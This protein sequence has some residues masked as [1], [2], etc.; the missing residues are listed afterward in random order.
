[1]TEET[2]GEAPELQQSEVAT[3]EPSNT[4][5]APK[6]KS[7]I[8]DRP[9]WITIT[10][11]AL[12]P[13][14]AIIALVMSIKSLNTSRDSLRIGQR[15]YVQ[16]SLTYTQR[17]DE[18][19]QWDFGVT[20]K[21]T[22]NTPG[23]LVSYTVSARDEYGCIGAPNA[24]YENHDDRLIMELEASKLKPQRRFSQEEIDRVKKCYVDP[25]VHI[26]DN[27]A[28]GG[29]ESIYK[30]IM[31]FAAI[32]KLDPGN[33]GV[34]EPTIV[35]EFSYRDVFQSV[36]HGKMSCDL[37]FIHNNLFVSCTADGD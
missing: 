29:K 22:G 10:L 36:H 24:V 25:P 27:A 28:I 14:L 5:M 1:M 15:A 33:M 18:T 30:R 17:P 32:P 26:T 16:A 4:E 2:T 35:V 23:E 34:F 11:G 9:H 31:L 37:V 6:Q 20:F 21:N 8:A 12:S 13:F 7:K 19:L 3:Q